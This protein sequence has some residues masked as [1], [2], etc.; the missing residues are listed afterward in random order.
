M[1]YFPFVGLALGAL[2]CGAYL[3]LSLL[4]LPALAVTIIL[5]VALIAVT[6]GMH[7]D[8]LS[9]TADAFLSG[10]P[11]ERMLEIMRDPHAG[12]MGV[13]AIVSIILLKV[14]LLYSFSFPLAF[15]ALLLICILSRWSMVF[16]VFL[17]PY[18]RQEGKAR[19]FISGM[20]VKIF[21]ISTLAAV[22]LSFLA[23]GI[24][25][26]LVLL[27]IAGVTYLSNRS[28]TRKIGGI[29]G[30]I[31]GALSEI[32]EVVVLALILFLK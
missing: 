25:G 13:L 15:N 10:K 3:L 20:S 14:A 11:K 1:A 27:I 19:V 7:L 32:N 18:A 31:I 2:L 23:W 16:S 24:K 22:I 29:T 28:V 12:A 6:G 5:V 9:D 30:D 17:S 8:G 4:N 26:L 21:L